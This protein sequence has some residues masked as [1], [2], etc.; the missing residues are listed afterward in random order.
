MK[1]DAQEI[2][3]S[4][5][6][7][8]QPARLISSE[9]DK[10]SGSASVKIPDYPTVVNATLSLSNAYGTD[11]RNLILSVDG[12]G[13]VDGIHDEPT[14]IEVGPNPF[15]SHFTVSI[16]E[17]GKWD[18]ELFD[19]AGFL[20]GKWAIGADAPR[21]LTIAPAVGKGCYILKASNGKDSHTARIIKR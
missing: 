11:S 8:V 13:E 7:N 16:P 1:G 3:T 19:M 4:V 6:W 9:G 14:S 20:T 17:P 12:A 21:S 18:V 5:N 10:H 2:K 15:S